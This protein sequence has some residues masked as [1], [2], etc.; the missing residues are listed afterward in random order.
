MGAAWP[1]RIRRCISHTPGAV[2][3]ARLLD[4]QEGVNTNLGNA[5]GEMFPAPTCFR[6]R[7]FSNCGDIDH[8]KS[9]QR[10]VI[11]TVVYGTCAHSARLV[12][13]NQA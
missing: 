2:F 11:Y 3:R 10:S 5:L 1:Y 4:N 8:G 13:P 12:R 9:S 6:H 7:H